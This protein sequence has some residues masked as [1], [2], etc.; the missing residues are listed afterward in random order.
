M[1]PTITTLLKLAAALG[2]PIVH[3]VDDSGQAAPV[4]VHLR[5]DERPEP[6]T[7]W[8]P[9]ASGVAA[10]GLTVPHD[11]LRG[12]AVHAVIKPG[13]TSGETR[14]PRRGEELLLVL[15]G[16]LAVDVAGE[17][18]VL[19]AGDTLHYPTDRPHSWHNPDVEPAR[20]VWWR[21]DD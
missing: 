7:D 14:P 9:A 6:P 16:S 2:R 1:V 8:A 20:A 5:A 17:H 12:S 10:A 19:R 21:L 13:G 3:F 18:Y 4:A 11:R 15:E